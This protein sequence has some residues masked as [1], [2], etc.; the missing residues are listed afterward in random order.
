MGCIYEHYFLS[1]DLEP[2]FAK[3]DWVLALRTNHE[4]LVAA[5]GV[6]DVL[7]NGSDVL[8]MEY[9]LRDWILGTTGRIV[10]KFFIAAVYGGLGPFTWAKPK[11]MFHIRR[12]D[13]EEIIALHRSGQLVLSTLRQR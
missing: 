6:L 10:D 13:V 9:V 12:G 2:P 4:M 11:D 7:P 8:R 3:G 1:R 5:I